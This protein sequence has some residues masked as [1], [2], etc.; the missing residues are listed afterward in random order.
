MGALKAWGPALLLEYLAWLR[1][2]VPFEGF[3]PWALRVNKWPSAVLGFI[4]V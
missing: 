2:L 3:L 1:T 4:G